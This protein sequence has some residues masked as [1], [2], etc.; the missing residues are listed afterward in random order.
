M[1]QV[2]VYNGP[3]V[4]EQAL[5][6]VFQREVDVSSG[7]QAVGR[8]LQQVGA[9]IDRK[10]ER[11]AEA[12]ANRID[13]EITT[14]WLEW[15]A[16]ARRQYQGQNIDQ[17]E[18][19]AAKWWEKAKETHKEVSPLA[20]ER[21][22]QA[23]A[24][25]R[26]QALAAASGYANGIRE[27][28]ADD[29]A[30]AAA[31]AAI[32]FGI[33]TGAPAG[34]AERVRKIAVAKGARKGWTT[35]MVQAE[36]QRLL[37]T[38]HLAYITRLAESNPEEAAK[39][40]N[41]AKVK[42]EIPG[43]AQAKIEQVLK[44]EI[45]NKKATQ[46]AAEHAGLPLSEQLAKAAEIK[47]PELREKT[48]TQ[49]RNNHAMVQQAT[50]ERE[51][52]ASDD[53]WQLVGQG[54]RVP[55]ALLQRMNGRE[56]V[57]LQDHLREKAKQAASGE[58]VKT[59]WGVY[60][61]AREALARGEKVNLTA[62]TTKVAPAQMEQ[63][64]DIATKR[65]SPTKAPEVASTEQQMSAFTTQMGL[66]DEKKG[67]FTAAAYDAFNAHLKRTGKE[68]TYEERQKILDQL[69]MDVVTHEGILWDSKEPL[70]KLPRE[71]R[72]SRLASDQFE[73]GK[74]YRDQQT[75]A[76][77]KYLGNGKWEPVK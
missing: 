22:G 37:G 67:M 16:Q 9:V 34:A 71:E 70:Y 66:K 46:F 24:R 21:I 40:Y 23:L 61:G 62:L 19:E 64:L 17:Y 72:A 13:T 25:K 59:D 50:R 31:Q 18:A 58:N 7:L 53:A 1:P 57:Q 41:D 48:L 77:A 30:E 47:D 68:P 35:E 14:G 12:E 33:D 5:Q 56:R 51:Q 15:D 43:S 36:Q 6:P 74:V 20:R 60:I 4:R 3:Q 45:D 26:A 32:E 39:Y 49:V 75:G 69:A 44:G 2:P 38:L 55:E 65:N 42:A 52:Q 29:S 8:G 54:K 63:L 27:K 73:V 10:L 11:D 76:R 28:F